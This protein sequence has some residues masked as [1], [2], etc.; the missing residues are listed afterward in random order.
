MDKY[1]SSET[2]KFITFPWLGYKKREKDNA[3]AFRKCHYSH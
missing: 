2:V 1:H 3:R